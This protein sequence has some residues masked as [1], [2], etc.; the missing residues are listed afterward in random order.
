MDRCRFGG[1]VAISVLCFP[2]LSKASS[3]REE[4]I[5]PVVANAGSADALTQKRK[6]AGPGEN[7][8]QSAALGSCT[9]VGSVV[10]VA[11][12]GK[13]A[14]S[15]DGQ[16]HTAADDTHGANGRWPAHVQ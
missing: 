3:S 13:R 8:T 5:R 6:G 7:R 15:A 16:A 4:R 11:Q 12:K 10:V 1:C 9:K 14:G 2:G